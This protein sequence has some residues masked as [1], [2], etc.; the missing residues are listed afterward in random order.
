[1]TSLEF[2]LRPAF[3]DQPRTMLQGRLDRL[4]AGDETARDQLIKLL[5]TMSEDLQIDELLAAWEEAQ[6]QRSD[7]CRL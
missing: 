4:R 7:S 2:D 5:L 3:D 6:G 1:L